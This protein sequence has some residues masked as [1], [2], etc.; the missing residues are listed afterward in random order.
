MISK[1]HV[2]DSQPYQK[3][4][5]VVIAENPRVTD[6]CPYMIREICRNSVPGMHGGI[7]HHLTAIIVY[8]FVPERGGVDGKCQRKDDCNPPP[9]MRAGG[10]DSSW[11]KLE[12][13]LPRCISG[14]VSVC[15]ERHSV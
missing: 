4:R 15:F 6:G 10:I 13:A 5:S 2:I 11:R 8:E 1:H 12:R 7:L 3:E 14:Y 9:R